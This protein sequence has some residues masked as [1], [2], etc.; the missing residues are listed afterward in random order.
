M[1]TCW[2]YLKKKKKIRG[3]NKKESDSAE[4]SGQCQECLAL[5]RAYQPSVGLQVT[6]WHSSNLGCFPD[7]P[8]GE[9][10]CCANLSS[11]PR[12]LG[13]REE[14]GHSQGLLR[15]LPRVGRQAVAPEE[16]LVLP[17]L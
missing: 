17:Q 14:A 8:G 5:L 7:V 2:F 4:Y 3:G 1:K 9:T 11:P 13:V 12:P 16:P 6:P 10:C 15:A